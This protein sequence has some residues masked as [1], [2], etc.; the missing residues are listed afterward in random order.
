MSNVNIEASWKSVLA[1]EFEKEYWHNLTNFVKEEIKS[2]HEIYPPGNQIFA[3]FDLC[4]FDSV[5][6][7]ILGQDPYHGR[8]QCHGPCFSVNPGIPL[9]PSLKNIFKELKLEFPNFKIP[10]NGDLR[11]WCK[12]GVLMINTTLTVRAHQPMSHSGKGWEE[13]TTA[14]I[15]NLSEKKENIVFLLW[16]RHARTKKVIISSKKHLIL[17]ASHPSPFSAN[18]GFFGCNHFKLTNEYLEKLGKQPIDWQT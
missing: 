4:P 6:V 1:P 10:D 13:F 15:K 3:A 12:Q 9:P 7:V 14:A 8:G 5:E 17:E 2:G 16:G 11:A 18:N